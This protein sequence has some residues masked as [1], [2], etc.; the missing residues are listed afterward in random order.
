MF[1]Y[2]YVYIYTY[3]LVSH[4]YWHKHTLTQNA[5]AVGAGQ[6]MLQ[7]KCMSYFLRTHTQPVVC[8]WQSQYIS[9]FSGSV[10]LL[11]LRQTL[12]QHRSVSCFLRTHAHNWH[13]SWQSQYMSYLWGSVCLW[14]TVLQYRYT[15]YFFICPISSSVSYVLE[16][17]MHSW[18]IWPISTSVCHMSLVYVVFLYHKHPIATS[19]CHIFQAEMYS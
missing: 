2:T 9:Q 8:S 15:S 1:I 19:V 12:L 3:A 11:C 13:R 5:Y 18:E 14:K 6:S 10:C 17:E 4:T 16:A 7:H